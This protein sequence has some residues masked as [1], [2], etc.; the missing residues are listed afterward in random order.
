MPAHGPWSFPA[1]AST[2]HVRPTHYVQGREL[3]L[4]S[5]VIHSGLPQN[6]PVNHQPPQSRG[7][8]AEQLRQGLATRVTDQPAQ[9]V[10]ATMPGDGMHNLGRLGP[11]RL[12]SGSVSPVMRCTEGTA[13]T[14]WLRGM[15][16][17][18]LCLRWL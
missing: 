6:Q 13:W 7:R 3:T 9:T 18:D 5:Q 14:L 10:T 17:V 4:R 15:L 12:Q 2:Q 11:P 1:A 8:M 16:S